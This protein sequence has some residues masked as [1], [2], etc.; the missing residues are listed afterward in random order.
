MKT[1][2]ES[3]SQDQVL[4]LGRAPVFGPHM[5][6]PL[7]LVKLGPRHARV[8]GAVLLHLQHLVAVVKVRPQIPVVRV[9]GRPVPRLPHLGERQLVLGHL[10]VHA[11][12][13][14]AVPPPRAARVASRLVD[15][16][17]QAAVAERLEHED[18][19]CGGVV[20]IHHHR[21][22]SGTTQ[23]MEWQRCR[24]GLPKP[25]PT[26]SASTSRLRS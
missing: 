7:V 25:A 4:G 5:P 12:A 8:E 10:A 16:R 13:R 18:A 21:G 9:V 23:E 1:T 3:S 19:G 22:T 17:L 14:I 20:N 26:I 2:Y 11:R 6:A 15:D 24:R